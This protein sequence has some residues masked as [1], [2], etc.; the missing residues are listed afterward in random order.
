MASTRSAH[1]AVARLPWNRLAAY[2]LAIVAMVFTMVGLLPQSVRADEATGDEGVSTYALSDHTVQGVSPRGTTINLFDYWITGQN[3]SDN[4]QSDS[5]ANSGINQHSSYFKF[6]KGMGESEE[7]WQANQNNV[8]NWTKNSHPRTGIVQSKLGDD[9]YP[10]F[11]ETLGGESL[12]YLFSGSNLSGKQVYR[13]VDGLLQVD[14]D[15]YYYYN[16]QKNFA[17]FNKGTND[18]TLYDTWGVRKGGNSPDGQFFPFNTGAQVLNNN[19]TQKDINSTN[20][21]INHYFGMTMSTRFAQQNG[22]HTDSTETRAVTYNFSGDDDVW[23]FIDGVLVGDLGGIHNKTALEINFATGRV[24]V[25]D[26]ANNNNTR[27]SNETVYNGEYDYWT[28]NCQGEYLAGIMKA[29]GVTDGLTDTTFADNTYHTLNFFYLER[30]NTDSNMSL[31]YNLVTIPETDIQKVDQVGTPLANVTF[32]VY[33]TTNGNKKS[34]C[35]AKTD[36]NG[37]VVLQDEN[38]FPITLDKLYKSGVEQIT[39]KRSILRQATVR[40]NHLKCD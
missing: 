36:N 13:D 23:V 19:G 35:T 8:N 5:D 1:T 27:D 4:I 18:F 29:A 11:S 28:K 39:S 9:G 32:E 31:K 20:G 16:S 7:P 21:I 38:G 14:A 25:Y 33:D 6:G 37:N 3:N 12:S 40:L 30:G 26:D 34:I 22:G 10:V 2:L 24:Y 15:G 17:Q